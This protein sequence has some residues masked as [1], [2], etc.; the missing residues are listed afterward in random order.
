ME[1][2]VYEVGPICSTIYQASGGGVDWAYGDAGIKYSYTNELRR[3]HHA[4]PF[5]V[6]PEDIE[7]NG[8]EM[9]AFHKSIARDMIAE[10]GGDSRL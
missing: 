2:T 9:M 7:P 5:L 8:M 4:N 10:F 6:D 1:G 3:G